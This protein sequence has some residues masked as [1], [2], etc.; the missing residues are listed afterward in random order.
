MIVT[1]SI[2]LLKNVVKFFGA[3]NKYSIEFAF[4]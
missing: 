3:Q 2:F 1:V 4:Y